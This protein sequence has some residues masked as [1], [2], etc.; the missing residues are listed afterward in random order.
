[1]NLQQYLK[2]CSMLTMQAMRHHLPSAMMAMEIGRK[3]NLFAVGGT[4]IG[5]VIMKNS[6]EGPQN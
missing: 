3:G 1:M 5:T 2:G 4:G 6:T